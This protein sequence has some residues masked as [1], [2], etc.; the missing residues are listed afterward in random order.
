MYALLD[1]SPGRHLVLSYLFNI[2]QREP[3]LSCPVL[4]KSNPD[5]P[6]L[7]YLSSTL[8]NCKLAGGGEEHFHT[9][10]LSVSDDWLVQLKM[11]LAWDIPQKLDKLQWL[12]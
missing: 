12:F 1:L 10:F 2:I 9:S 6:P 7:P 8:L 11:R 3:R 4:T 5:P